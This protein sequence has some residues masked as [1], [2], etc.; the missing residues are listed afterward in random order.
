MGFKVDSVI[1]DSLYILSGK[2]DYL[3]VENGGAMNGNDYS[4][5]ADEADMTPIQKQL[6]AEFKPMIDSTYKLIINTKGQIIKPF[7]VGGPTISQNFQPINYSNC[8]VVFPAGKIAIGEDWS[9]VATMP[10]VGAK[11]ISAYHIES[12]FGGKIQ[13]KESGRMELSGGES[14]DF[15]SRYILDEKTKNLISAKFELDANSFGTR[16]VKAVI[17]IEVENWGFM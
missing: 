10:I 1:G 17:E 11:R 7:A 13:I 14:H 4:S 16:N 12:V 2:I 3:R 8:Q 6:N 5:D 9:A 15:S